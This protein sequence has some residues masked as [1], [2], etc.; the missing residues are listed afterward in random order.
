MSVENVRSINEGYFR[1]VMKQSNNRLWINNPTVE[2]AYKAIEAGAISCTTNPTYSAKMIQA[3][4][5]HSDAMNIVCK[6]VKEVKDDAE[7]AR[8]IQRRLVK[9]I[10]GPFMLIYEATNGN[11][12]F[13]SIQGDPYAEHNPD[14]IIQEA[15][16]DMKLG[17]N[18]IAKIPVTESGLK[19]IEVL[20]EEDI[21]IIATE[22]MGISQAIYACDLY[23]RVCERTGKYP[24]FYITHITGIFDQ[25][26]KLVAERDGI[27]IYKDILW[28]AG[29]IVARKQY[30]ILKERG[31]PVTMLGGGARGIH[32][33]TEMIGSDM[34]ITINWKGTAD[35][36]IEED[37]PVV[38]RMDTPIPEYAVKELMEKIPDFR[39]AYLE[40]GLKVD[41]FM[42]YGPVKLFRDIFIEGWDYLLKTVKQCREKR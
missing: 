2:E 8:I 35:K 9:R 18:V 36:L 39:K 6:V 37:P 34:H 38:Y 15:L 22:V 24:P 12:G 42:D 20:L 23:V 32:H 4:S 1:R 33:F 40:D 5:E 13:V 27:D 21:P 29:C 7:A 17:K 14:N 10:L 30:R 3:E 41:E 31:Y 28:Q 11:A 26:M 16:E 19:A 25:Y